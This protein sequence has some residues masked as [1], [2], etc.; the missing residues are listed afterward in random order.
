MLSDFSKSRALVNTFTEHH[1]GA[2]SV[3]D[4]QHTYA[5]FQTTSTNSYAPLFTVSWAS[6]VKPLLSTGC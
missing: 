2:W 3:K 6:C 4:M 1:G 5:L